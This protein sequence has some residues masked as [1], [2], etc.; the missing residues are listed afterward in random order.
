MEDKVRNVIRDTRKKVKY[1]I[2]AD[3]KL[4]RDEMLKQ[5]RKFMSN[6]LNLRQKSGTTVEINAK[7]D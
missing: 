3:K 4:N 5:I 7:E 6:P 2:W 1:I